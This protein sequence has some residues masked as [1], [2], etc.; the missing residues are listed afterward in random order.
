MFK[1]HFRSGVVN[2]MDNNKLISHIE[3]DCLVPKRVLAILE[4]L[5]L[6]ESRRSNMRLDN[7]TCGNYIHT[8]KLLAYFDAF[9]GWQIAK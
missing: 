5:G 6:N 9:C 7:S 2:N 1:H 4:L 3:S 8:I